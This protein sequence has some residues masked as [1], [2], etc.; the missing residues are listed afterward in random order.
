MTLRRSFI[1]SEPRIELVNALSLTDQL[2]AVGCFTE[3]IQWKKRVFIPTNDK[4][5]SILA[6]VIQILG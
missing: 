3:I 4:A 5:P 1:A 2:V 6:A